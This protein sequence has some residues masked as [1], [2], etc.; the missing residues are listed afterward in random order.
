[1]EN[2]TDKNLK[3]KEISAEVS[4]LYNLSEIA[5]SV[6]YEINNPLMIIDGYSKKIKKNH[7][8]AEYDD[9][10]KDIDAIK[11]SSERINL[12]VSNLITYSKEN[13]V[14]P[15]ERIPFSVLAEKSIELVKNDLDDF[16]GTISLDSSKSEDIEVNFSLCVQALVN[17]IKECI[18]HSETSESAVIKLSFR[19][20]KNFIELVIKDS[21]EKLS[22]KTQSQMFY[23]T[24]TTSPDGQALGMGMNSS[25]NIAKKFEGQLYFDN[26]YSE[27]AFIFSFN[28][29][30]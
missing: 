10:I 27:N 30:N 4:M 12:I 28:S 18:T 8:Q 3:D 23:Q 2:T 14:L 19:K 6:A 29:Y 1:M 7:S 5:Q 25:Y 21:G 17:V 13:L 26:S 11:K 16:K 20:M 15:I 9:L 24:F 22:E